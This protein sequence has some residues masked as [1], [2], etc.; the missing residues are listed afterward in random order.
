MAENFVTTKGYLLWG[1]TVWRVADSFI[2]VD[3]GTNKNV[4]AQS[5][6]TPS[7]KTDFTENG[8]HAADVIFR[9]WLLPLLVGRMLMHL[10]ECRFSNG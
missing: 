3:T 2:R 6:R 5:P 10:T 4:A 7:E 8:R 9:S 1:A